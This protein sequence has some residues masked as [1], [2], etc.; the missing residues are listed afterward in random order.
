MKLPSPNTTTSRRHFAYTLAEMLIA[1][2]IVVIVGISLYIG[3]TAGFSVVQVSRE[4]LR[5]TQIMLQKVE[6]IRLFNWSQVNNANYLKPSFTERY[7]PLGI[8]N[9]TMGTIYVG[10]VK[11]NAPAS[12]PAAY[13]GNMLEVTVTLYWTNAVGNKKLVRSREMSTYVARYGMQNYVYGQ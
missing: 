12:L 6:A 9:S 5:A 11:T 2:V 8:T 13:R 4:N 3:L 7:D 10:F 1:M